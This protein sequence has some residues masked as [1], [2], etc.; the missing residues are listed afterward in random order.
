MKRPHTPLSSLISSALLCLALVF[1]RAARTEDNPVPLSR[2][3]PILLKIL[4]F[5]RTFDKRTDKRLNIGIVYNEQDPAS[6]QNLQDII[7][8]L[9][10]YADKTIKNLPI[11]YHPISY[12]NEESLAEF[13]RLHSIN[14]FYVAPGNANHIA[15]LLRISQRQK[16]ITITGVP[17]YVREGVTVGLDLKSDNKTQILI[18]LSTAQL[19]GVVFDANLLRLSTIVVR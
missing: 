9:N 17:T 13:A 18:N 3:I 16:I 1:P 2:Q 12:A 11:N 8:V 6:R 4:T 19:E 7:T 14:V 15:A 5:D 10:R